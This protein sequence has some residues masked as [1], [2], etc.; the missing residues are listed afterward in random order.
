MKKFLFAFM[1]GITMM[2]A[3]ND[4][5]AQS[6]S[7]RFG[8]TAGRDNTFRPLKLAYTALTDAAGADSTTIAPSR[9]DNVYRIALTDSFYFKSPTVTSCYAGDRLTIIATGSSGNKLKFASTNFITAGTATLSS[10]GTAI[11]QMVFSGAKWI[12]ASRVVQ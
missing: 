3:C 6:T 8:T 12:E 4:T 5:N 10:S 7:P 11:I 9:F 1:L 2:M